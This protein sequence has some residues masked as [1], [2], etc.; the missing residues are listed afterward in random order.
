MRTFLR[1]SHLV[2][3]AMFGTACWA[4]ACAG[5]EEEKSIAPQR[6]RTDRVFP[7]PRVCLDLAAPGER[8]FQDIAADFESEGGGEDQMAGGFIPAL[9]R[10][11][12]EHPEPFR[13][14]PAAQ[15]FL[16]ESDEEATRR[17]EQIQRDL[18][19]L[20]RQHPGSSAACNAERILQTQQ[21]LAELCRKGVKIRVRSG[22]LMYTR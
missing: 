18:A 10:I 9:V 8:F 4:G 2:I 6:D 5:A 7:E 11:Q 13:P 14:V 3:V 20:V 15:R 19:E 22:D 12:L 1:P 16:A 21:K 17:Y